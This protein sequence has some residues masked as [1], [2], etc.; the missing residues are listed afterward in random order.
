MTKIHENSN[1]Q[2]ALLIK[3][4]Y[5]VNPVQEEHPEHPAGRK[6]TKERTR[7]EV[8]KMD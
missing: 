2:N 3:S 4:I 5:P 8:I 6:K 1:L 7:K